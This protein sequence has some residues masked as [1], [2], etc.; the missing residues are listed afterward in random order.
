M[1]KTFVIHGNNGC[2]CDR[3]L[4]S[5]RRNGPVRTSPPARS[6]PPSSP[7]C[8]AFCY[9][10]SIDALERGG[11]LI[12]ESRE[13]VIVLD[14]SDTVMLASRRARQTIEGVNEG[15][16]VPDGCSAGDIGLV[17]LIVPYE[18]AP[19]DSGSSISA[20]PAT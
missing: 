15:E 17:P 5:D 20:S 4:G 10:P 13:A 7:R 6:S 8:A 12:E 3:G 14:D 1:I 2:C 16:R 18:V 11:V 19:G 9:K